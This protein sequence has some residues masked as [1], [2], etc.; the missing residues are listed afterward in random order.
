MTLRAFSVYRSNMGRLRNLLIKLNIACARHL[1][2]SASGLSRKRS[3]FVRS[4]PHPAPPPPPPQRHPPDDAHPAPTHAPLQPPSGLP[5]RS[6]S[7][8]HSPQPPAST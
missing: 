5:E 3:S 4:A 7:A 6:P 2:S 1:M 8:P